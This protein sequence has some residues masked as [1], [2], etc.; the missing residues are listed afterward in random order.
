[1]SQP[2]SLRKVSQMQ[3]R[4]SL[5]FSADVYLNGGRIGD[6]RNDGNGGCDLLNLDAGQ[7]AHY[8]AAAK[9]MFPQ[10]TFEVEEHLTRHLLVCAEMNC[11]RGWVFRTA[12]DVAEG[13]F[14]E[15]GAYRSYSAKVSWERALQALRAR[16]DRD[17]VTVWE[18]E[19]SDWVP[20]AYYS[21]LVSA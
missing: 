5:A 20:L 13:D 16:E 7:T 10:K 1:M 11:K 2:Y 19:E 15:T 18:P 6:V 12:E 14:A 3:G 8:L 21:V 17:S 9:A 4:E